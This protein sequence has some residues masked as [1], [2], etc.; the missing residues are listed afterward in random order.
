MRCCTGVQIHCFDLLT[1]A[2]KRLCP[3]LPTRS[4]AVLCRRFIRNRWVIFQSLSVEG[5]LAGSLY[6]LRLSEQKDLVQQTTESAEFRSRNQ[7]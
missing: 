1:N 4:S 7:C 6:G 3:V 5:A 2:L